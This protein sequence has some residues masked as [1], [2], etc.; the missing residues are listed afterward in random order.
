M[1]LQ[2]SLFILWHCTEADLILQ[3]LQLADNQFQGQ[4]LAASV[5]NHPVQ[6]WQRNAGRKLFILCYFLYGFLYNA[7]DHNFRR[8]FRNPASPHLSYV[9]CTLS[10]SPGEEKFI[11]V[12]YS[13]F[14][15]S[16]C[17]FLCVHVYLY[18]RSKCERNVPTCL[19]HLE[20]AF[21]LSWEQSSCSPE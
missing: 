21:L 10:A 18:Y 16:Y 15:S 5:Y 13:G 4:I 9:V 17:H 3:L 8:S 7:W 14:T 6:N 2:Q 20:L 12:F 19:L 11:S 1:V